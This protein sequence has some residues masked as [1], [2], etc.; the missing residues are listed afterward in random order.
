M[1]VMM[2]CGHAAN[3]TSDGKPACVICAMI[4]SGWNVVD[5]SPPDLS[6]RRARCTDYGRVGRYDGNQGC[7]RGTPCNCEEPSSDG[8]TTDGKPS[9]LAFFEYRPGKEFDEFYCGCSVGW[10]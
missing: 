4:D 6:Q 1:A 3:A 9:R 7:K 10:D 8:I 2:K 5:D